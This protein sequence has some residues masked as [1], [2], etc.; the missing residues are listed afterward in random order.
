LVGTA[1]DINTYLGTASNI[2]YT[3]ALNASGND[4]ATITIN[5]N[6]GSVNPLLATVNVDITA[7]NDAPTQSGAPSDVTVTEDT[8]S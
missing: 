6:D 1:A 5:A 3:G 4:Q 7:T 8:A 2:Q